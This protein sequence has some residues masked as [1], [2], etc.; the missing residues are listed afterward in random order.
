MKKYDLVATGEGNFAFTEFATHRDSMYATLKIIEMMVRFD[1]KLSEIIESIPSFYYNI[2]QANCSQALKGKMMRMFL[3]DAKGK[4]SST[5]DGVKIWLDTNDWIL[6]IPDQYD[7][8][9]NLYI[10]AESNEK[11]E[12]I[13][14]EYTAK[15]EKWSKL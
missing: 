8:Q 12:A 6:M 2:S 4:D 9:L 13:L 11:G 7:D 10:Q 3:E 1:V 14:A 15:I 5:L